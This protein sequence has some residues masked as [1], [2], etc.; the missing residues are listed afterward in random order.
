[1]A[2][3]MSSRHV[4]VVVDLGRVRRNAAEVRARVKVPVWAT[5]KADAYGLGAARVAGALADVVDGYCVFALEE[6]TAIDI[7]RLTGGRRVIALGPPGTLDEAA[8]VGAGVRP[9]VSTVEQA[10]ALRAARPIVCVDTGMQRFACSQEQLAEVVRAGAVD[11]AFTH[12]TRLEHV[13]CLR[14]ICNPFDLTLHAAATALLDEPGAYLDGVRP[15]FAIYRGAVRVT[16]RLV[17][18]RRSEGPIGYT[19]WRSETGHHGVILAGYSNG[20][21]GGGPVVVN[22]RRQRVTEVGMQSAYVTL[23]GA[24][25]AGDE[26][27]LL[28]DG[29]GEAEVALAWGG[30]PHSA[31][32]TLA[33]MGG[34]EYVSRW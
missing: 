34:R 26:A 18:A 9:A 11:E 15:G 25:R 19:R 4:R 22:G 13:E 12:A 2:L 6:A 31:L 7:A 27:V 29:V 8:W 5:V 21:R 10:A 16:A 32:L 24:D 17:E 1:M 3:V 30:T 20:L 33:G 14:E 28:G 23:D